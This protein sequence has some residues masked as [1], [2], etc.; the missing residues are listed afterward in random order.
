MANTFKN[1]AARNVG[2][3]P[4]AV[5][6]APTTSQDTVIG[7]TISNTTTSPITADVYVSILGTNYYIIKGATVP[8]GGSLVPIGGDQKVVLVGSAGRN[9][10]IYV[11]SSAASSAD[12]VV[13]YLEIT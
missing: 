5:I 11:V 1:T 4:V 9:D 6:T 8:V 10:S 12:V 13:S 3:T 7:M 2:T